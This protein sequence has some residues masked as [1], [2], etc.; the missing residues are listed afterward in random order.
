V[1]FRDIIVFP[2]VLII[3]LILF[4]IW[5]VRNGIEGRRWKAAFLFKV[6][7]ALFIGSLYQFYYGGGDTF[8]FFHHSKQIWAGILDHPITG[9]K[10]VFNQNTY[11]PE[12]SEYI[13]KMWWFRDNSSMMVARFSA[14][15][16]LLTFHSYLGISVF[17]AL[18][19]FSSSYAIYRVF[20]DLRPEYE[21]YIFIIAFFIPSVAVWGSGLFKD[22]L[23][24]T[25]VGWFVYGFYFGIIKRKN[26]L[27]N[28]S[29]IIITGYF[30][31]IIKIYILISLLPALLV[32]LSFQNISYIRSRAIKFLLAPILVSIAGVAGFSII[33]QITSENARYS[34]E[35]ISTTAQV[36]AMDIYAGW[37]AGSGSAYYLGEQDG[38]LQNFVSL[39]P[40]ALI[41][42]LFRPWPWEISNPIMALSALE[43]LFFLI[44]TIY[45]VL[46]VGF[47]KTMRIAVSKPEILFSL[48]FSVVLA[49]GVGIASYNFGTLSRYKIPLLPFYLMALLFILI[50]SIEVRRTGA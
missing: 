40:S 24:F 1:E 45:I 43:S 42:S 27:L 18:L 2:F 8:N 26:L 33:N 15:F 28:S 13:S 12:L 5:Q 44:A 19:S 14:I 37:G 20:N 41:V 31:S 22:T 49:I 36:T 46:R 4:H 38:S 30:L 3:V 35:N 16:G 11:Y 47:L 50:E 23:A 7:A 10:L 25:M 32:W 48:I 29:I 17:F 34:L 6:L 9:F 39:A 21:K